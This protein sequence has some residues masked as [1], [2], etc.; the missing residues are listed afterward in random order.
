MSLGSHVISSSSG[1][2]KS[3]I[4]SLLVFLY[5][6][7]KFSKAS[8]QYMQYEYNY[9]YIPPLA[10]TG[11]LPLPVIKVEL[12]AQELPNLKWVLSVAQKITLI[13]VNDSVSSFSNFFERSVSY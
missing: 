13:L 11:A 4:Q 3:D 6:L 12:P 8:L 7:V 5:K 9:D 1:L 2:T 10:M